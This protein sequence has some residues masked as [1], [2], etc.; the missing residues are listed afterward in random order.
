MRYLFILL[1]DTVSCVI[2]I[3]AFF[4]FA[5][6][7]L[8]LACDRPTTSSAIHH[9]CVVDS[10]KFYGI[11]QKHTLQFDPMWVAYTACGTFSMKR[12]VKEGDSIRVIA[13]DAK[14]APL[15]D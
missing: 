6:L 5:F 9:V 1:L 14:R 13:L 4:A 3:C 11:G 7:L 15:G 12:P 8:L 2:K 10:V